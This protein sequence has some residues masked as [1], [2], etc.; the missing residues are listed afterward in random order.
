MTCCLNPECHKPLNPDTHKFCQQCGKPL[1]PFLHKHYKILQPLGAGRWGKTYLAMDTDQLDTHCIVK[2]LALKTLGANSQAVQ[3]FQ[4]EAR[5]LQTLGHHPQIPDLLAY[6]Q[7]GEYLYLIHQWIDGQ[8]LLDLLQKGVLEEVQ[9][10]HLLLDLLPVLQVVHD[11]GMVHRDLKPENILQNTQGQYVLID[12]GIAQFLNEAQPLQSPTS[13]SSVGYTPPEQLQPGQATPATPVSDLY[14]LGATCFHLLSRVSPSDLAQS[15]GPLWS[16]TWQSHI[17]QPLSPELQLVLDKLLQVDPSQRYPSA[18]AVLDA[19]NQ[20]PSRSS[21]WLSQLGSS[22]RV[23]VG[24][25]IACLGLGSVTG[26]IYMISTYQ[27]A[28]TPPASPQPESSAAFL[29]RGDAKYNR[30]EYQAAIEDY[31]EAIRLSSENAQA[32]LGRGNAKYALEQYSAALTDYDEALKHNPEYA[33]A[34]NGRGNVKFA[35]KDYESAIKAYNQAIQSNPQFPLAFVNRGNVKS[36]LREY[37]AAI[38]DYSQAIRLNPQY[39]PAYFQRG[40]TKAALN[41]FQGAIKDYSEAIR[42]NPENANAYNGRGVA[43]YKLGDSRTAIQDFTKAIRLDP[44]SPFPHCNRG[45]AKLKLKDAEGAIA[46]CTETIRLDPQ[47]SFAYSAR[48]KAK[49]SLKRYRAAIE[50]YT[51]AL[52]INSGWGNSDSPADS[53]YNRGSAK[54]QLNDIDDAIEDLKIAAD[55]F[56]QQG[57]TQRYQATRTLLKKLQ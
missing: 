4:T 2:Q 23:W 48:G 31:T 50:D 16:Q 29:R 1:V 56:Q 6:F 41:N 52:Q 54:S 57:D 10:R 25:A 32:Y 51:Q 44:D 17:S 38:E 37:R 11:Q 40:I 13:R 39:E 21:S 19:L 8:T 35:L 15:H 9:I 3:L 43:K 33:Y 55:L 30:Q 26:L 47:S 28:S 46:D 22:R 27:T 18:Q 5:Q 20:N 42:L 36:A 49:H 45:E 34:F 7:E 14:G 24:T 53:Y 12:F